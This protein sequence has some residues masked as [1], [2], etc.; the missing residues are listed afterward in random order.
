MIDYLNLIINY[1]RSISANDNYIFIYTVTTLDEINLF[2]KSI[3]E[4][5]KYKIYWVKNNI[6]D[7]IYGIYYCKA[8]ITDSYHGTIFSII[9][10]KPFIAFKYE[11]NGNDRFN[12]L[13]EI[14]EIEN[15]FYDINSYPDITLLDKPL[16]IK[17]TKYNSLK[18]KSIRFLKRNLINKKFKR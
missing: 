5:Y 8:V 9:F 14:F 11:S 18:K 2:I 10:N 4:K 15:R 7:F 12:S 13:K 16:N 17:F 3:K 1:N 6:K